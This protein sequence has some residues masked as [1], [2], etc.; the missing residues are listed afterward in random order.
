MHRKPFSKLNDN[1]IILNNSLNHDE[2]RK[3]LLWLKEEESVLLSE[4]NE[5][6]SYTVIA[7]NH[8]RTIGGIKSKILQL[9]KNN[10]IMDD[11]YCNIEKITISTQTDNNLND[12]NKI[13]D[14][15]LKD[16]NDVKKQFQEMD[17]LHE[18]LKLKTQNKIMNGKILM[19]TNLLENVI[20]K[21]NK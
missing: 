3:N 11:S 16:F 5:N 17:M 21:V 7:I 10:K 4:L 14:D 19:I 9:N 2:S 13:M 12:D 18:I 8:K 20:N 6:L 15:I 1:N